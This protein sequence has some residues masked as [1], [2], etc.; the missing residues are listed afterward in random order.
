MSSW[1]TIDRANNSPIW[2]PSLVNKTANTANRDALYNN[3]T[4]D[5]FVTGLTVGVFGVAPNEL[6]DSLGQVTSVT[7]G[8]AGSGYTT[9]ATVT[10]TGGA[11]SGAVAANATLKLVSATVRAGGSGYGNGNVL[12]INTTGASGT[13]ATAN[14][15]VLTTNST[16][17]ILTVSVNTAGNFAIL[18]TAIANNAVIGGTGTNAKLDL[19]FGILAVTMTANG[20]GYTGAPTV[21]FGGGGTGTVAT[22]VLNTEQSKVP[23]AGWTL[24]KELSNGRVQYETLIAAR[25][26][27]DGSDDAKLPE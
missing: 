18:P 13:T 2:G 11:G 27:G 14:V 8:T 23:G 25:L 19:S 20:T 9:N 21:S 10:F 1:G 22:A 5:A 7:V 15:N 26:T 6:V 24:R 17:G 4:P 3:T 12:T 16:G